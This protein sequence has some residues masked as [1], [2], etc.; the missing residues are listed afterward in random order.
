MGKNLP[1]AAYGNQ[2]WTQKGLV[3]KENQPHVRRVIVRHPSRH[4]APLRQ[5]LG[6][7]CVGD[8]E[9]AGKKVI[10]IRI[11]QKN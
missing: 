5:S 6:R 1:N 3:R 7:Y 11:H 9:V 10:S 8:T 2:A 4:S